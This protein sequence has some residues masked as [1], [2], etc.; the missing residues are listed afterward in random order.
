M[1]VN[2]LIKKYSQGRPTYLEN[3]SFII[4]KYIELGCVRE[5]C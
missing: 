1:F 4:V 5:W 3:L 2:H